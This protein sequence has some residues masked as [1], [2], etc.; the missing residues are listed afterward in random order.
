MDEPVLVLNA[1]Y[2]PLNV[3]TTRRA[4][5]LMMTGKAVMLVNGRGVI[6]SA[7]STFP[8]PSIVRLS[9][10][11]HRPRPRAKLTKQ[12]I[13]RRDDYT[14]QYCGKH[15]SHLTVDHVMPRHRGG[16]HSW[17][18]LV[19][20]CPRC[21]RKKGGHTPREANMHLLRQPYEP[22]PS[23]MYLYGR[24]LNA[25]PEWEDYLRGW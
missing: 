12:E 17:E 1:N 3:C 14:C 11:V 6:R 13:F 16:K 20:A 25:M 7:T 9:Y 15:T 19:A 4:F 24:M 5:G 21:N 23:A 8:R 10:M 2:E 18:N 22:T